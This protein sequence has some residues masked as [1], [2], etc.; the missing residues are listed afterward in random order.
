[1]NDQTEQLV[2][3]TLG[4]IESAV[5]TLRSLITSSAQ[6]HGP[7]AEKKSAEAPQPD[8]Q[9]NPSRGPKLFATS[10]P[11]AQLGPV[12][13]VH[14]NDWP[15]A[16]DPGLIVPENGHAEK[17]FRA[18]QVVSLLQDPEGSGL[19]LANRT[20]LDCGCGEGHNAHEMAITAGRVIGYD[21]SCDEA[22]REQWARMAGENLTFTLDKEEVNHHAPYDIVVLYDVIDHL[23]GEDPEEFMK[24]VASMLRT[25]GRM[26]VRAHPWTSKT[27]GHCYRA[28][29][30]A[31]IHLALT[32]SE[33]SELGVE[34]EEPNLRVVRPMAAYEKWF[35][36]AGLVVVN[37]KVRAEETDKPLSNAIVDRIIKTTWAGEVDA[38]TAKRIMA[39]HFIDYWLK[40]WLK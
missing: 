14:V 9:Q 26:F 19:N 37:K 20:V 4:R 21:V 5:N 16:V 15:L 11:E 13:D 1:M 34:P 24:W 31:W 28:L 39:N 23:R 33:L 29:N 38:Q 32:P 6:E 36:S 2:L 22:R 8:A 40:K 3:E 25:N 12:P 17:Q 27:G 7:P 35:K 10:L 18:M 30:K